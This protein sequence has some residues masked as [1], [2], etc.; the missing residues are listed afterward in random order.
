MKAELTLHRYSIRDTV[1][2]ALT[3]I[4]LGSASTAVTDYKYPYQHLECLGAMVSKDVT[5]HKIQFPSVK[6]R[7]NKVLV[8]FM[9]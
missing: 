6:K 8:Q 3:T 4:N 1:Y 7:P 9:P 2:K 5:E